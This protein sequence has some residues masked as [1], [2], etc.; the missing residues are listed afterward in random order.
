[1]AEINIL[2][3]QPG[4]SA[5]HR[6]DPRLKLLLLLLYLIAAFEA[7][8]A[9]LLTLPPMLL[10]GSRTA[11]L[12]FRDF[13]RELVV[14]IVLGGLIF[15]S[16]FLTQQQYGLAFAAR[17]AANRL[18]F[19]LLVV[20]MGILFT[21]VTDP[22]ELYTVLRWLFTPVPGIPA[23]RIA[24]QTS[25]TLV[26]IPLLLDSLHEIR[27][28]RKVRGIEGRKNPILRIRSLLDPLFEKLLSQMQ[29]FSL[30]LEARCYREDVPRSPLRFRGSD[31]R[32]SLIALTPPAAAVTLS[33]LI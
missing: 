30:A 4:A 27:E 22:G 10:L 25:F 8:P 19:F 2:H 26:M 18:I 29:D 14:F 20:W 24:A 12:R 13:R 33:L 32:T 5:L 23:H 1:M 6:L 7:Q 3:Y 31:L 16:Q 17:L 11:R 28:A 9:A 21:A 15:A